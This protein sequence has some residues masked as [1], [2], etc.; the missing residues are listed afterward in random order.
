MKQGT[1][2][3]PA[4]GNRNNKS[5]GADGLRPSMNLRDHMQGSTGNRRSGDDPAATPARV[6]STPQGTTETRY[7]RRGDR[8]AIEVRTSNTQTGRVT[9]KTTIKDHETGQVDTETRTEPNKVN[10]GKDPQSPDTGPRL[11]VGRLDDS[12]PPQRFRDSQEIREMMRKNIEDIRDG[13]IEKGNPGDVDRFIPVIQGHLETFGQVPATTV[14]DGCYASLD[15][16][17]EGRALGISRVVF[18]KKRGISYLDMG[19]KKKTFKRLRDFRAGIEGNI[20]E[21][22]RVFGAS[23]AMWKGLD[24]F[25]AFVWSSVI[26]YNLVRLAK[27]ESG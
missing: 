19:V 13:A 8:S 14:S 6:E 18:H 25:K 24:G 3:L 7:S 17:D 27:A 2:D 4:V 20:S 5:Y 15:N 26:S 16:V 23:K 9:V 10:P 21:L 11:K 12:P 22:K 1:L